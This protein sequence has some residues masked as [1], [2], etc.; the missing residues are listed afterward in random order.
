[1]VFM[2]CPFNTQLAAA[3]QYIRYNP[4]CLF[5]ATNAD[6][7]ANASNGKYEESKRFLGDIVY[8]HFIVCLKDPLLKFSC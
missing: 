8:D 6:A 7:S 1:M 2:L 3:T 5:I 4:G